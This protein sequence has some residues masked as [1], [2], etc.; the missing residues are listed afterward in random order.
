LDACNRTALLTAIWITKL[1]EMCLWDTPQ[2]AYDDGDIT[3]AGLAMHFIWFFD[4][5]LIERTNNSV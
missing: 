5:T 3:G 4:I 2:G 1:I